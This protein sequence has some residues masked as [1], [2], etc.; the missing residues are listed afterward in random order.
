[1]SNR[2]TLDQR[3][4][5]YAWVKA[6]EAADRHMIDEYT[7]LAK[8]VATLIMN[9]GLMQTLAFLQ[10]KEKPGDQHQMLK[11]HLCKWLGTTLGG[12]QV[13]ENEKFPPE[14]A[15]D[16]ATVMS[17]LYSSKSD[18]YMRATNETMALLRWTRQL[19]DAR[20]S[21]EKSS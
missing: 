18:L 19:A 14:P 7:N 20:K 8:S 1:M 5:K 21:I 16:F 2:L 11:M 4:A 9:S 12:S 3:R 13:T 6:T 10:S 15:A 17:A